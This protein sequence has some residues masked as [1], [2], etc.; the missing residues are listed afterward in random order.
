[1][2]FFY[3]YVVHRLNVSLRYLN[4]GKFGEDYNFPP[5]CIIN[6][7]ST[8]CR[9]FTITCMIVESDYINFPMPSQLQ[10][11]LPSPFLGLSFLPAMSR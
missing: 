3:A 6:A 7:T 2:N 1:M 10:A 5:M 8:V 11:L 9:Y 4:A